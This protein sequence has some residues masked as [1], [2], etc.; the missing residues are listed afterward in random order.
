MKRYKRRGRPK[1]KTRGAR[2]FSLPYSMHKRLDMA[3][4]DGRNVSKAAEKALDRWLKENK[5]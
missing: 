5:Y 2:A 3:M 1:G 4:D